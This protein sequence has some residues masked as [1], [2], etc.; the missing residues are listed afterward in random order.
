MANAELKKAQAHQIMVE[1]GKPPEAPTPG[2]P[3]KPD[4][5]EE[6][7]MTKAYIAKAELD[8]KEREVAIK[9]GELQLKIAMASKESSEWSK[10]SDSFDG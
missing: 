9:E 6:E 7:I 4:Y 10:E 3:E 1:M 2:K 8:L 5:K